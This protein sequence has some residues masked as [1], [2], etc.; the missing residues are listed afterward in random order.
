LSPEFLASDVAVPAVE[1]AVNVTAPR[2][3][4]VAVRT[5]APAE[6]PSVQDPTVAMPDESV[7]TVAPV[8]DPPPLVTEN[9]TDSPAIGDPRWSLMTTDG[10]GNTAEPAT[11]L[12]DVDELAEIVVATAGPASPPPQPR[13]PS[14]RNVDASRCVPTEKPFAMTTIPSSGLEQCCRNGRMNRI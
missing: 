7:T 9:V 3:P 11:P 2:I 14:R 4:E 13:M 10:G 12:I 8:T 5:F 1:V 6:G